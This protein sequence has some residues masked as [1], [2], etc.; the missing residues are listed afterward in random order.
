MFFVDQAR[1]MSRGDKDF[2]SKLLLEE[3]ALVIGVVMDISYFQG[4]STTNFLI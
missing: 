1:S 3:H 4:N 2:Y